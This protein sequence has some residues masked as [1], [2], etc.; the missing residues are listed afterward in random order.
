LF[1][2]SPDVGDPQVKD[3]FHSV[4]IRRDFEELWLVGSRA[5]A[6]IENNPGVSQFDVAGM[7]GNTEVIPK[8][9]V[10]HEPSPTIA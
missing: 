8:V 2:A 9:T 7:T 1:I 10:A 4:E 6:G 5:T 3:G